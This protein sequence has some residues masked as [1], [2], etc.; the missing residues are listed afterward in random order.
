M[1]Y[2]QNRSRS[3]ILPSR[4]RYVA[5]SSIDVH[6]NHACA[7]ELRGMCMHAVLPRMCLE[8]YRLERLDPGRNIA[9]GWTQ[10]WQLQTMHAHVCIYSL[11]GFRVYRVEDRI[12]TYHDV[13]RLPMTDNDGE[14]REAVVASS[15]SPLGPMTGSCRATWSSHAC[16]TLHAY[17]I[18]QLTPTWPLLARPVLYS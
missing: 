6:A 1:A 14:A 7:L 18:A 12:C 16:S 9:L 5:R 11:I 8:T 3:C 15:I 4:V 10:A 2:K 17:C 13:R